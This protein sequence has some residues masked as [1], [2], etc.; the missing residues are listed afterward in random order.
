MLD[1]FL[2]NEV[3]KYYHLIVIYLCGHF[4]FFHP[5]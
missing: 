2:K 4:K 5:F 1:I 3:A